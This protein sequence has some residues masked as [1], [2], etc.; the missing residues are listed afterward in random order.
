L[1]L[2]KYI[3]LDALFKISYSTSVSIGIWV[4]ITHEPFFSREINF[5]IVFTPHPGY[6]RKPLI[7]IY[8]QQENSKINF[9]RRE[10]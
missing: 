6:A 9:K 8:Y 3:D 7:I 10:L 2:C 1:F 5:N 4:T